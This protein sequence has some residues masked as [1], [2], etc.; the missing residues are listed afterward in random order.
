MK[1]GRQAAVCAKFIATKNVCIRID[2]G[3]PKMISRVGTEGSSS[4][5]Q[6][7]G[8]AV[9]GKTDNA[10]ENIASKT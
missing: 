2:P 6:F 10:F 3:I 7:V 8:G 1:R 4:A 5:T 9:D